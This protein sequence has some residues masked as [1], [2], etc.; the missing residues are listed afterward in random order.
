MTLRDD[1]SQ[2][3]GVPTHLITA[4]SYE[5]MKAQAEDLATWRDTA[6]PVGV[7]RETSTSGNHPKMT[8]KDHM[9]HHITEWINGI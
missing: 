2:R 7:I 6:P 1:I 8:Q 9:Y 3:Y 4:D 5:E